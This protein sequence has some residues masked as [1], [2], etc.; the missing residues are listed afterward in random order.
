[1]MKDASLNRRQ[2]IGTTAVGAAAAALPAGALAAEKEK[3]EKVR[4]YG[5][6]D[7]PRP[8]LETRRLG[9]QGTPFRGRVTANGR[10]MEGL[11]VSNGRDCV[12]TAKDGS[13]VLPE[14]PEARFITLT[15]P[16]GY[17]TE[18]WYL[19]AWK[20][21]GGFDF[22]LSPCPR[23]KADVECKFIQITDSEIGSARGQDWVMRLKE[24]AE[25]EK[26]AFIV[27]TGDICGRIGLI[28]HLK[29][30]NDETMGLRVCYLPGNHDM[31]ATFPWGEAEF[32]ALFGP[33]WYSFEACGVHFVCTP[34]VNGDRQVSYNED[35]IADWLR[36][37]LA[38]I[39]PSMP[40]IL[41]NHFPCNAPYPDKCGLV[42]GT[43][44]PIDLRKA[45]NFKGFVFG[46]SHNTWFKRVDGVALV[47]SSNPNKS[48]IDHSP[49]CA[50]V[51]TVAKKDGRLTS[52]LFYGKYGEMVGKSADA[53]WER[54]LPAGVL[55]G[56]L[57]D[58]G[59]VLYAASHDD[60][61]L[62]TGG[63]HAISKADGRLVWSA[64]TV[65]T[66]KGRLAIASGNV[67]GT[68]VEGRVYAFRASDG[69]KAWEVNLSE[70]VG[71]YRK[72]LAHGS[73]ASPDGWQVAV[74]VGARQA[75]IDAASGRIVWKGG[76]YDDREAAVITPAFA[77]GCIVTPTMWGS[78]H[79]ND[80]AT[81]RLMWS[82]PDGSKPG[83]AA[84]IKNGV[85]FRMA[86]WFLEEIDLAS[87]RKIRRVEPRRI[88]G[89]QLSVPGD[90]LETDS[91]YL[92]GTRAAGLAAFDK[93]TL[94]VA[95]F[96]DCGASL[97]AIGAYGALG[98]KCVST[99]PVLLPDGRICAAAADGAVHLWNAA[100]G[101]HL[102]AI[103][104]GVAYLGDVVAT[105][106]TVYAADL[107]GFVR[108]FKV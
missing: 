9:F 60:D 11:T 7:M 19:D 28:S 61:G 82:L 30:M 15:V 36:N 94:E 71:G 32:E 74:G 92:K 5:R 44:R 13:Y 40:V 31:V 69:A 42:Y 38:A 88:A 4:P 3:A 55:N 75:V 50:R 17:E 96:G 29:V 12:K 57:L 67:I 72:M 90:I 106:N 24:L 2:F 98:Q 73:A 16:S 103:D 83:S 63:V 91:L 23:T 95:W 53:V 41:F 51:L 45:C 79:C 77:E 10:P 49:N 6:S 81:G 80:A 86:E 59:D 35:V 39:D 20:R 87:G 46:H 25:R 56:G 97:V 102:R 93:K 105:G 43:N 108:A 1:M 78:F 48:G 54:R 58:G 47:C 85:V 107:A 18:W 14:F 52:R 62:G 8:N 37:D 89:L 64:P 21:L 26:C 66:I 22:H 104:T 84:I 101:K 99:T 34:M 65:N 70:G 76:H 33:A 100:D 68:D 27:H